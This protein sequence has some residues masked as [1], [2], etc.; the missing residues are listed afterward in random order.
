MSKKWHIPLGG[1][2][3]I[4]PTKFTI[5]NTMPKAL[6]IYVKNFFIIFKLFF[7]FLKLGTHFATTPSDYEII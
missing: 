1:V 2:Q 7:I 6:Y 4:Y 3:D 5:I